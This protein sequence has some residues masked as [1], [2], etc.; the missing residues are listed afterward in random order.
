MFIEFNPNPQQKR[1]G[2]CVIRAICKATGMDWE[3]T[4]LQVCLQGLKMADMPS[5]NPVWATYLKSKGFRQYPIPDTCPECY[6]IEDFCREN[7]QGTY[8]VGTG[9]HVVTVVDGDYYDAWDSGN[10]IPVFFFRR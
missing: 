9:T 2:D 1:V 10:E 5:S 4:Y 8:I 6:T 7:P 3:Q